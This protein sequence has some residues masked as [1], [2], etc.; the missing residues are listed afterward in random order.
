[1][2]DFK[3]IRDSLMIN[4]WINIDLAIFQSRSSTWGVNHIY[5]GS[6]TGKLIKGEGIFAKALIDN[7]YKVIESEDFK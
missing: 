5:D 7:G 4:N 3:F 2:C 6:F 1:M